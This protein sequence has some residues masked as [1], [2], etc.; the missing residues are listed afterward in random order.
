MPST[1][2]GRPSVWSVADTSR[3][4]GAPVSSRWP[5]KLVSRHAVDISMWSQFL[6][7]RRWFFRPLYS[8]RL[9]AEQK[10]VLILVFLED[11]PIAQLSPYYRT[12]KLLKRRTYLSWPRAEEH[13]EVFWE[14]LRQ[15]LTTREDPEG[16]RFLLTVADRRWC[17]VDLYSQCLWGWRGDCGSGQW[18]AGQSFYQGVG[19]SIPTLG[20]VSLIEQDTFPWVAPCSCFYG[21]WM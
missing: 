15:A 16:D 13:P 3:A 8:Y 18:L 20:D 21:G 19:G 6:W 10:D 12:R 14:K 11:I 2:A 17:G 1:E 5:G 4:S 9:F 7:Q